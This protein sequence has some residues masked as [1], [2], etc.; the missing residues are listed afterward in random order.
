MKKQ[1]WKDEWFGGPLFSG[2]R[3]LNDTGAVQRKIS[4]N[5]EDQLDL[6]YNDRKGNHGMFILKQ[7]CT[8][9]DSSERTSF[10]KHFVDATIWLNDV[11]DA[12]WNKL[13]KVNNTEVTAGET[14]WFKDYEKLLNGWAQM[15]YYKLYDQVYFPSTT[16]FDPR[17]T[18]N[19]IFERVFEGQVVN[20]QVKND[21]TFGRS[22]KVD[23]W[24]KVG[25]FSHKESQGGLNKFP[26]LNGKGIEIAYDDHKITEGIWFEETGS[27]ESRK[28]LDNFNENEL[29]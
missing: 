23:H 5:L 25:Y 13:L 21:G 28:T 15:I 29:P 19:N 18:D 6:A 27:I 16:Q 4:V 11:P 22:F 17:K 9:H 8:A 1:F 14:R 12:E 3:I 24:C 26:E 20:G 7:I 10:Q 2:V